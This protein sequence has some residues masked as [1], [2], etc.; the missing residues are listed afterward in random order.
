MDRAIRILENFVEIIFCPLDHISWAIDHKILK[1][2]DSRWDTASTFCWVISLYISIFKIIKN[3]VA[4]SKQKIQL[5]KN[6]SER[7]CYIIQ[8]YHLK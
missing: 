3:I 6:S 4:I 8:S 2:E 7:Y 1:F 5:R